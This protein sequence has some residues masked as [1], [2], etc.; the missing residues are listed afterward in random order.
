MLNFSCANRYRK[1]YGVSI[2]GKSKIAQSSREEGVHFDL[3]D[4][5]SESR[6][7]FAIIEGFKM[8][9]VGNVL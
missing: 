7:N 1:S 2:K 4:E 9:E 8:M 5:L 3:V 6:I